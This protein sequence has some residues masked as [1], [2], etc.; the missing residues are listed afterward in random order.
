VRRQRRCYGKRHKSSCKSSRH[1]SGRGN[2]RGGGLGQFKFG[3]RL[4]A[5]IGLIAAGLAAIGSG[6]EFSVGQRVNMAIRTMA[7]MIVAHM[8]PL[9]ECC[10]AMPITSCAK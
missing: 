10:S 4:N 6:V 7:M 3:N 8:M 1:P 9:E 5:Q 2:G